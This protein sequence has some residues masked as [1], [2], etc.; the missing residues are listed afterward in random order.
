MQREINGAQETLSRAFVLTDETIFRDARNSEVSANA[1]KVCHEG[2]HFF[3]RRAKTESGLHATQ[4]FSAIHSSFADLTKTVEETGDLPLSILHS[5]FFY[6]ASE[7]PASIIICSC[8]RSEQ[9]GSHAK[10][11]ILSARTRSFKNHH[12]IWSGSSPM[13]MLWLLK[14]YS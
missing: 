7:T 6:G 10:Y 2:E 1:Y 12:W 11:G 8:E 14:I 5:F 9:V 3:H 13:L 4:V